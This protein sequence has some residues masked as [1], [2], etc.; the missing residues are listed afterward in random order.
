MEE[1]TLTKLLDAIEFELRRLGYLHGPNQPAI[2]VTSAFGYDQMAFEQWLGSVF[3]PRAR[4][5]VATSELPASSQVAVAAYRNFDGV[6][7][8]NDLIGLLGKFDAAINQL[9]RAGGNRGGA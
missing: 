1:S 3:L 6:E 7:E 4:P 5:A 2:H 9:G 8:A